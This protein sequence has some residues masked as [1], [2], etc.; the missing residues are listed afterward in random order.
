MHQNHVVNTDEELRENLK[1]QN[2][3][4]S[5]DDDIDV[6]IT[7]GD[8]YFKNTTKHEQ[9]KSG[10]N[11]TDPVIGFIGDML[12]YNTPIKSATISTEPITYVR[13]TEVPKEQTTTII[14]TTHLKQGEPTPQPQSP[15]PEPESIPQPPPAAH[16]E[17]QFKP[18]LPTVKGEKTYDLWKN[19]Y[20]VVLGGHDPLV[21]RMNTLGPIR[22]ECLE[23]VKSQYIKETL[24][25]KNYKDQFKKKILDL[26]HPEEIYNEILKSQTNKTK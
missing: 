24:K 17:I 12:G 11:F 5:K 2:V 7:D 8:E 15:P 1:N 25:S 22:T 23:L 14:P 26:T 20:Y 6:P 21:Q 13:T 4:F 18:T 9:P 19:F 3:G 16:E 10:G